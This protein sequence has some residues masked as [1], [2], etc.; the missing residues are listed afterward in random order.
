MH[1]RSTRPDITIDNNSA[2]KPAV[3]VSTSRSSPPRTRRSSA[4][5]VGSVQNLQS[6]QLHAPPRSI[7]S[8]RSRS[9]TPHRPT[10]GSKQQQHQP[11]SGDELKKRSRSPTPHRKLLASPNQHQTDLAK[12]RSRS[13]TPRANLRSRSPTPRK[14]IDSSRRNV[15]EEARSPT[16]HG[17]L[18]EDGRVSLLFYSMRHIFFF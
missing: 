14:N 12:Q 8:N 16:Y 1:T 5:S 9:P 3:V 11:Q 15:N 4:S 2:I 17:K 13:P 10:T 7:S 6:A 18:Q